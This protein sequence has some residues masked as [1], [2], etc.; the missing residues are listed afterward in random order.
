[1]LYANSPILLHYAFICYQIEEETVKRKWRE[2][3]IAKQNENNSSL[4]D[5]TR[6]RDWRALNDVIFLLV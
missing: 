6:P 5:M 2:M 3:K 4:G 1:M